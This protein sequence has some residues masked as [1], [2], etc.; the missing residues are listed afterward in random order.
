MPIASPADAKTLEILRFLETGKVRKQRV[1]LGRVTYRTIT[2]ETSKIRR[3]MP[4]RVMLP[5]EPS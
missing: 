3:P 2:L 1:Y 4:F 5:L